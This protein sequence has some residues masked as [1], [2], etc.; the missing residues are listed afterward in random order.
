MTA[1][2]ISTPGPEHVENAV[3]SLVILTPAIVKRVVLD[4]TPDLF[5]FL[6]ALTMLVNRNPKSSHV[7]ISRLDHLLAIG[8]FNSQTLAKTLEIFISV[9]QLFPVHVAGT[10]S[11]CKQLMESDSKHGTVFKGRRLTAE[12]LPLVRPESPEA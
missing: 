11:F 2:A 12:K 6:S 5:P 4:F 9:V 8:S 1:K 10:F 3:R 7:L